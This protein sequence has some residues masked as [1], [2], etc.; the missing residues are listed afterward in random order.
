ME[1]FRVHLSSK[2][3]L[4]R[5]FPSHAALTYTHPTYNFS[6]LFFQLLNFYPTIIPT[7]S[8]K[9]P[10]RTVED[11][12]FNN[13]DRSRHSGDTGG[14]HI[15]SIHFYKLKNIFPHRINP[16]TATQVKW[17]LAT[18]KW[19]GLMAFYSLMAGI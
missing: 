7:V 8:S 13:A 14:C 12:Y 16:S 19:R 9:S 18:E 11:E 15:D 17:V 1:G 4:S 2:I 10:D 5:R 3:D 6:D